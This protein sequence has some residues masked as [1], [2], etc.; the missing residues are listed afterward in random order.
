VT[1]LKQDGSRV[2]AP[3]SRLLAQREHALA[4]Q[5][6]TFGSGSLDRVFRIGPHRELVGRPVASLPVLAAR[7]TSVEVDGRVLLDSVDR[8]AGFVP[9]FVEGRVQPT[10]TRA[11]LAVA[12]NGRVAAVTRTFDQHGQTRFSAMVPEDALRSGRNDVEVFAVE[13]AGG[14]TRLVRLRGSDLRFSLVGGGAGIRIGARTV[15]VRA[16]SLRGVVRAR[17]A[18]TGWV[19][20]G[21]AAQRTANRRVDT[22]V[23][24][25]G[26]RAVYTGRAENLKPHAILGQPEL[27]KTGFEFELPPS[28]LPAAGS[29]PVRVFALHDHAA[30]EL[31]YAA[32]Y[33]WRR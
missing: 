15:P 14:E 16:G 25:V 6:A 12:L 24:F 4:T 31:R 27:G 18:A 7:A 1:V 11:D 26:E 21:F 19:F 8:A 10:G 23:V 32:P 17:R 3:L 29:S 30:A 2:S 20:S 13:A 9:T 28:L 22:I 5:I 33:P